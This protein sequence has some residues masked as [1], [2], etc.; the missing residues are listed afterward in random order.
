MGDFDGVVV[1]AGAVGLT[2]AI[3]L[4]RRGAWA[5]LIE[6]DPTT[7]QYPKMDRSNARTM[8][9]YRRIGIAD[10]VRAVGY[11]ADASMDVFIVTR[12]CDPPMAGLHYPSVA[13][14]RGKIAACTDGSQP[15]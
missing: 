1:G 13:E 14:H 7:K 12:L 4:G 3:D 5:L 9:F 6:K 15:L 2:L 8:E 11:P 10:R